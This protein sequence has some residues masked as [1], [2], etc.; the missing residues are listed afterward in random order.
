MDLTGR[1]LSLIVSGDLEEESGH[2]TVIA[3][4]IV[5]DDFLLMTSLADTLPFLDDLSQTEASDGVGPGAGGV[6]G[7]CVA[8]GSAGTWGD[9]VQTV[10]AA[11]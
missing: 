2:L 1:L 3:R 8:A 6:S 10:P 5:P 11:T 9:F 7:T 4:E